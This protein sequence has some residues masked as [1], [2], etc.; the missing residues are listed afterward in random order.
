MLLRA[1]SGNHGLRRSR[2]FS[3]I[4]A[5]MNAGNFKT[6]IAKAKRIKADLEK[7][8]TL[9]KKNIPLE[10]AIRRL[11]EK[12]LK[13]ELAKQLIEYSSKNYKD[14]PGGYLRLIRFNRQLDQDSAVICCV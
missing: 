2:I 6:T 8:F 12:G 3:A 1:I 9:A 4:H 11:I 13:T 14:R 5:L 10:L 7:L